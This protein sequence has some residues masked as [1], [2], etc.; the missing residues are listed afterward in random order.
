MP[1]R[2]SRLFVGLDGRRPGLPLGAAGADVPTE[3]GKSSRSQ[4]GASLAFAASLGLLW[5]SRNN[6]T[7]LPVSDKANL[8][9]RWS[10]KTPGP[11]RDQGGTWTKTQ[12]D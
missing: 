2:E 5:L 6:F 12:K 8:K 9:P 1:A 3:K 4:L 10:R 11:L 7:E